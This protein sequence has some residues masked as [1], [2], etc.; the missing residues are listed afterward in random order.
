MAYLTSGANVSGAEA[1]ESAIFRDEYD[2]MVP[3]NDIES[4]S[5]CAGADGSSATSVRSIA[6]P[7]LPV[8]NPGQT[9]EVRILSPQLSLIL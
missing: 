5:L 9:F 6:R 7:M 4:H 2:E 1:L 3:V 8:L